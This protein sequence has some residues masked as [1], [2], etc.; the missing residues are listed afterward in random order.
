MISLSPECAKSL[1]LH[2]IYY[3]IFPLITMK[4]FNHADWAGMGG[5]GYRRTKPI[6]WE[7]WKEEK[8]HERRVPP[9][10]LTIDIADRAICTE[11][12]KRPAVVQCTKL[13]ATIAAKPDIDDV[14]HQRR[15][16]AR[17]CHQQCT[18]PVPFEHITMDHV[19]KMRLMISGWDVPRTQPVVPPR[20]LHTLHPPNSPFERHSIRFDPHHWWTAVR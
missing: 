5:R 14:G 12:S 4:F 10:R 8:K 19:G 18:P 16:C 1:S 9:R 20:R 13:H 7:R 11:S 3:Q 15:S 17:A 6:N 2:A